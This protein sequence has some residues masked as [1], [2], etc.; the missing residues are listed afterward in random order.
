MNKIDSQT[1]IDLCPDP[2]IGVDAE[3]VIN[4]FNT[5]AER[6]MGYESAQVVGVL[7]I[8]EIYTSFEHAKKIKQL[9]D[10]DE[11]GERGFIEGYETVLKS[12]W[13]VKYRFACQHRYW[14]RKMV[15]LAV[16][17]SSTI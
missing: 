4:L 10:S 1:L 9:I 5:A 14:T 11:Y 12:R 6:L 15:R 16:W 2:I 7:H 3:G 17:A 8:A 13:G